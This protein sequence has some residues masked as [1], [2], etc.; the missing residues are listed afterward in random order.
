MSWVDISVGSGSSGSGS[1]NS[2]LGGL[3]NSL[4]NALSNASASGGIR[5]FPWQ[6]GNENEQIVGYYDDPQ[7][8]YSVIRK[9]LAEKNY[10]NLKHRSHFLLKAFY[11]K[12]AIY[13][14][15]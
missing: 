13:T 4:D 3:I 2:L 7:G 9:F 11:N 15:A 5:G 12:S 10:T 14:C 8:Y 6:A 1:S